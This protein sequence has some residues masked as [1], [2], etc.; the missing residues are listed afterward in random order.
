LQPATVTFEEFNG[1]VGEVAVDGAGVTRMAARASERPSCREV[2]FR[3]G[4]T[5][6][7][8]WNVQEIL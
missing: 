4:L 8:S 7:S 1:V 6:L 5:R 3:I 2:V